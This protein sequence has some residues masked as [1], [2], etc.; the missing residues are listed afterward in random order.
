METSYKN[1]EY[2]DFVFE[3]KNK[4]FGA[5]ELRNTYIIRLIILVVAVSFLYAAVVVIGHY[6][7][8]LEPEVKAKPKKKPVDLIIKDVAFDEKKPAPP[9]V[10]IDPPKV[11]MIKYVPP[12]IVPD[13]DVKKEE[14]P[15]KQEEMKDTN[16]GDKTQD[17]EEGDL[18][19]E[20]GNG[21]DPLG[22]EDNTIHDIVDEDPVFMGGD[23]AMGK[24]INNNLRY[25]A[26][27]EKMGIQGTVYISFLIE[28]D[29]QVSDVKVLK[30]IPSED[31]NKEAL[32][33]V[34]K[35][36]KWK[37]GLYQGKPVRTRM[38][39][40]IRYVLADEE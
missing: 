1:F 28:K 14:L 11:K 13:K 39:I 2:D 18:P 10:K 19:P 22:E 30:G 9:P 4:G 23:E 35:M 36:P 26:K 3:N 5:Y 8:T 24:F 25:P 37:P 21:K 31:C 20:T 6:I 17:G 32:R 12:K 16:P 33:V 40:P 7:S 15:P 38:K 34:A 29:G 27:A